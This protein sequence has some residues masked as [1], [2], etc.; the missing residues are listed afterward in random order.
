[1]INRELIR[2]KVVQHIYAYYANEGKDLESAEKEFVFSLSKSYELYLT[3]LQLMVSINYI[4]RRTVE[5]KMNRAQ[6]L[7]DKNYISPKFV[8]NRFIAQ[9]KA[10]KTLQNFTEKQNVIWTEEEEDFL[11]RT[12]E[13]ITEQD[14]YKKYMRSGITTYEEDREIWRMIYRQIL[15]DNDELDEILEDHSIYWN[16]DKA[17]IDTFILKTIRRFEENK[18]GD[19]PL[20]PEFKDT[21]DRDFALV[22]FRTTIQNEKY[23]R[24]LIREQTLNWDIERIAMM[25]LVIMQVA[26]AELTSF[27]EIPLS[28]TINEYVEVAKFYSTPRSGSYING[29]IDTIAKRLIAEGEI[30]E[31]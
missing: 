15:I 9:L 8:N 10:N 18:W 14:F 7:G 31:K 1:M 12:Y 26:L 28:V 25:D 30:E 16:D 19:Q 5:M 4:A 29:I 24:Q 20:L 3:L 11:R 27:P 23:F 21:E 2:Q 17:V 22:L 6:R 13:R